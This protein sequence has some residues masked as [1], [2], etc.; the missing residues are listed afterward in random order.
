MEPQTLGE[1]IKR[2]R[3]ELGLIQKQAA[4]L[5][6]VGVSTVLCWEK[7]KNEPVIEHLPAIFRL[8][9]YDPFPKPSTLSKRMLAARRRLGWSIAQAATQLGVDEGTWGEWERTGSIPWQRYLALVE[10]FLTG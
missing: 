4:E 6:G 10:E 5:L 7:S 9:G 3:L 2:R 1:H 8:L